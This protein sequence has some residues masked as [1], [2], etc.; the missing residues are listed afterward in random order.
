MTSGL[1]R[2]NPRLRVSLTLPVL[3]EGLTADG[4]NVVRSARDAGVDVG[5]VNVTSMDHFRDGDCGLFAVQAAEST[6]TQ[7]K[8]LF[9][10]RTDAQ[11][12]AMVGVTPMLGQN[13]DG[14]IYDQT[15]A[16]Q[17]VA[18]ASTQHPGRLTFWGS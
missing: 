17:L 16:R 13:D 2:A 3:P 12:W 14:H 5:L 10:G 15:N 6:F 18:F 9:P 7:L 8:A 11:V 4:L 1:Q